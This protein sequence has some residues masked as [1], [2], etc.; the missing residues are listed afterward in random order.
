MNKKYKDFENKKLTTMVLEIDITKCEKS[1]REIM[2]L[3]SSLEQQELSD[4]DLEVK[5]IY[6][7]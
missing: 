1:F 4:N 7:K 6:W 5:D 2:K 3:I